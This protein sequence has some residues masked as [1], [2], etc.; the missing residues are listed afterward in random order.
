[1]TV[2][3]ATFRTSFTEFT[4]ATI[5]PDADVQFWLTYA[6][7][8]LNANR[9]KSMLDL[10]TSLFIAHNL[11]LEQQAKASAANGAPPGLSSGIV[12]SKSVDKVSISYDT[13]SAA[14][15]DAGQWNLTIYG[16]RYFRLMKMFGAG[17][18]QV[19][20]GASPFDS[21]WPGVVMPYNN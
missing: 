14:E 4:S 10:G 13:N 18:L 2:T 1:M 3:V 11:V 21:A 6:G 5:Y 19:G 12:S 8:L 17:P 16:Q 9:W 7:L 20:I 15:K